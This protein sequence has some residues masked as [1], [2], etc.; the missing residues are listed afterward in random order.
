[1]SDLVMKRKNWK[2][3]VREGKRIMGDKLWAVGERI[4][5]PG[6]V[7]GKIM[8]DERVGEGGGGSGQEVDC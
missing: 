7:S 6:A 5:R 8:L 1:M 3:G 4:E 2:M